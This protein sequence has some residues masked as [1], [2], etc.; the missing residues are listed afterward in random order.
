MAG[1]SGRTRSRVH[2]LAAPSGFGAGNE[3]QSYEVHQIRGKNMFEVSDYLDK[4]KIRGAGNEVLPCTG[5][6][7]DIFLGT[8]TER[9]D[10]D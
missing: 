2:A 7:T 10:I 4:N 1:M 9:L 3:T 5:Y 6:R 8:P